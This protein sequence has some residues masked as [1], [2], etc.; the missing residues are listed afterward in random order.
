MPDDPVD[1]YRIL[2]LT[3]RGPEFVWGNQQDVLRD[4]HEKK[5]DASD[6]AIELPTGAGK[7]LVGGLIGEYQRRK[8]GERVAYLCP[9]RQLARQTAAKF[10]EYGIQTCCS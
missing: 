4:W 3:N 6:V 9:T 8:Y 1:L 5:S 7:T 2:A 10:D